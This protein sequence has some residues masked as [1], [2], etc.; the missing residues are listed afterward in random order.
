MHFGIM[1]VILLHSDNWHISA[2]H[3]ATFRVGR[4]GIQNGHQ[5]VVTM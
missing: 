5:S 2:N 3:V 1:N 4:T